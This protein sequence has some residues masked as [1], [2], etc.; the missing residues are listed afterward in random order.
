MISLEFKVYFVDI[1]VFFSINSMRLKTN[2][3]GYGSWIY[4]NDID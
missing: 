3:T 1:K 2:Q 4:I